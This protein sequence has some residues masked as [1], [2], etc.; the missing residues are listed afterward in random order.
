MLRAKADFTVHL[1][2]FR[3]S[4]LFIPGLYFLRLSLSHEDQTKYIFAK[5]SLVREVIQSPPVIKNK[6][7][8]MF[9]DLR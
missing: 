5:P 8:I 9:H 1:E 7:L 4:E 3:N 6:R 2:E